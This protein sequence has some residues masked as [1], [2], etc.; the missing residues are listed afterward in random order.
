MRRPSFACVLLVAACRNSTV[1]FPD[2]GPANYAPLRKVRLYDS[3]IAYFERSG[4][5]NNNMLGLPIPRSHLDDAVA[6]FGGHGH[7][8]NAGHTDRISDPVVVIESARL[9]RPFE[10]RIAKLAS[11]AVGAS[12]RACASRNA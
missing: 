5:V 10:Q 8:W 6:T 3:G 11:S 1:Q 2:T 4:P 9:A 7:G 12:R